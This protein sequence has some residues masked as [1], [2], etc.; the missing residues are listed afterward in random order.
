M[1]VY[2]VKQG[3]AEWLELR[4]GHLTSTDAGV[5]LGQ[6]RY[7][8]ANRLAYEKRNPP[9]PPALLANAYC[10]HGHN[11]EATAVEGYLDHLGPD[12]PQVYTTGIVTSGVLSAS[13]DL[14]VG[15]EGA[16]EIKNPVW[17]LRDEIPPAHDTQMRVLMGVA[18]RK[19]CDYVQHHDGRI[20]VQ[21]VHH[22]PVY[23]AELQAKL[24]EWWDTNVV[25]YVAPRRYEPRPR[26]TIKRTREGAGSNKQCK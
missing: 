22:D 18:G 12:R 10:L 5:V 17:G 2:N 23:W 16:A 14:L 20:R 13:P 19:W 3:S 6:S 8:A 25:N 1:R 7:K 11:M 15:L 9:Q 24:E 26:S 21:R 4:H